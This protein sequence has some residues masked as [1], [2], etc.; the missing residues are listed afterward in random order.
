MR[1]PKKRISEAP[2]VEGARLNAKENSYGETAAN[3]SSS[4]A[5][6]SVSIW[7]PI[8][9]AIPILPGLRLE[10]TGEVHWQLSHHAG[11]ELSCVG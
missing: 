8:S 9:I 5:L 10:I 7:I 11:R 6:E 3:E 2:K 4:T 1:C